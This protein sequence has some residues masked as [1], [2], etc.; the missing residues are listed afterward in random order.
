MSTY[1]VFDKTSGE[2]VHTHSDA[3]LLGEAMPRSE[4]D[5][6]SLTRRVLGDQVPDTLGVLEITQDILREEVGVSRRVY[7]DVESGV[8]RAGEATGRNT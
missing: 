7:V 5:L 2:I 3:S 4:E 1:V 6:L 8:L